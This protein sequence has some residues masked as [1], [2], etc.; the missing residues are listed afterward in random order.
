[1]LIE[2]FEEQCEFSIAPRK[3]ALDTYFITPT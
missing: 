2:A 1:M 3:S